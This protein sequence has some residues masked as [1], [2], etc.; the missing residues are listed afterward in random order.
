M[1]QLRDWRKTQG[2]TIDEAGSRVG[3]SG[4]QWHRYEKGTRLVSFEKLPAVSRVT[5]I[6]PHELRPD[7]ADIFGPV[8]EPAQ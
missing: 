8:S 3:V 5:G 6:S 1:E 7:L 4:V 2:L